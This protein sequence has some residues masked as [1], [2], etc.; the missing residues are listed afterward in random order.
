MDTF[1]ARTTFLSTVV[2]ALY[3]RAADLLRIDEA[4]MRYRGDGEYPDLGTQTSIAEQL[5][6]VR[7][8]VLV[9]KWLFMTMWPIYIFTYSLSFVD[10]LMAKNILLIST[11]FTLYFSCYPYSTP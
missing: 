3:R 7:Y 2:D 4:L 10:T 5:Q 11:F 1:N 9:D 6:L 8:V